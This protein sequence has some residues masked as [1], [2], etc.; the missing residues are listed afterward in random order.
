MKKKL[1]LGLT[2]VL[3][4][5]LLPTSM[6]LAA[7]GVRG[8]G[9]GGGGAGGGEETV[10]GNNLSYPAILT[11]QPGKAYTPF[12]GTSFVWGCDRPSGDYPNT[13]CVDASGA[14]LT[15][16]ACVAEGGPCNGFTVAT[17]ER[18]HGQ[19][20]TGNTWS[21]DTAGV[22]IAG[23]AVTGISVPASYLDWG[24]SLESTTWKTNSIIRVETTPF[25]DVTKLTFTGLPSTTTLLGY[26]MWHIFAQG[27]DEQWGV[28]VI[29]DGTAPYT[30]QSQNPI[31]YTTDARLNITKVA[32]TPGGICPADGVKPA[33]Y[34]TPI[35]NISSGIGTWSGTT[36]LRDISFTPELNVGGKWVYG[37]NWQLRR[38]VFQ[39]KAG[40]W[41]LTFYSPSRAVA[42]DQLIPVTTTAPLIPTATVGYPT[43]SAISIAAETGPLYVP[44]VDY[45][46]NLTYLDICITEQTGNKGGGGGGGGRSR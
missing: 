9:G 31:I 24:D 37:Y 1:A 5:T 45:G 36:E 21:A 8:P 25:A 19:K 7:K 44:V 43:A 15:P 40:W 14:P 16:D 4:W 42:F 32:S 35:W 10:V 13:A 39:N 30:Y 38:D 29:N 46:N 6:A 17:L 41:R 28:R 12:A 22:E 26:Q 27:P 33:G 18:I 34:P 2:A 23:T 20:T 3:M 11:S